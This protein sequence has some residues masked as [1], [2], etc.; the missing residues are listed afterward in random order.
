MGYAPALAVEGQP[1]VALPYG[2]FSVLTLRG[3]DDAHWSNGIEW[4]AMTCDPASSILDPSCTNSPEKF[5]GD[6]NVPGEADGFVVYGSATCGTPGSNALQEG[7]ERAQAHLLAREEAQAEANLWARLADEA[8]D[9]NPAGALSRRAALAKLERWM[10]SSYGSLGVI[11]APRD[12]ASLFPDLKGSSGRLL[13]ALGTPVAAGAG[14]PGTSPTGANPAANE[15]WVFAS[16]AVF[17]YRGPVFT[18]TAL[19]HEKNDYYAL[20]ERQYV[21]GFDPCGVAAVRMSTA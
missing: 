10:G 4:Q 17:G 8:V 12:A 9:I 14:Y 1:R 16:P 15:T 11:H 2:L 20:A 6:M 13:T 18:S 19:D 5:F 3:S 21:I 7:E